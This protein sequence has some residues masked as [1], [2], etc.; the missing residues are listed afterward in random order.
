M[1][2]ENK[3]IV[4]TGGTGIL[5]YHF[6]KA[7]AAAGGTVCIIGRNKEIAEIRAAE[8]NDEGGK[9]IGI[10]ADVLNENV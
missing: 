4:V 3:V 10:Y 8:I 2:L 1:K 5:G 9:A 7:I 6:N